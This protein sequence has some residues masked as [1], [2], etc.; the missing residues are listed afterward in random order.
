MN[1]GTSRV[2]ANGRGQRTSIPRF[3]RETMKLKAGDLLLWDEL[4]A[5]RN[6]PLFV[7]EKVKPRGK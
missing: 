3:V 2:Q 7:V 1:T 5:G 6:G 4:A